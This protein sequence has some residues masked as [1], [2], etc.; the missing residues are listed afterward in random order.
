MRRKSKEKQVFHNFSEN[1][2]TKSIT[3]RN[4]VSPKSPCAEFIERKFF[5][6]SKSREKS[7]NIFDFRG[8]WRFSLRIIAQGVSLSR[9]LRVTAAS[10]TFYAQKHMGSISVVFCSSKFHS[11]DFAHGSGEN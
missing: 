5:G 7:R 4:S 3:S 11:V 1:G 9:C 2:R 6:T 10:D 8:A